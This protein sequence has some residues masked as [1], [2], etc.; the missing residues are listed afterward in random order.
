MA[1]DFGITLEITGLDGFL[2]RLSDNHT[3]RHEL[4]RALDT[5]ALEIERDA[6]EYA[7][8]PP[9]EKGYSRGALR[10]SIHVRRSSY[11]LERLIGPSVDYSA[12][13]E[14]G[15][16]QRGAASGVE[17][18]PNYHYGGNWPGMEA[19]PYMQP[20]LQDAL[21]KRR[22]ALRDLGLNVAKRWTGK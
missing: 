3:T 5:L 4:R 8:N 2:A 22:A 18:P 14:Y 21:N 11:D 9:G 16:G 7:P 20:G 17:A 10:S 1:G 15:T 12:F 13:V 19:E 6:K